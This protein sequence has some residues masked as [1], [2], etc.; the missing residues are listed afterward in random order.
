MP[1]LILWGERDAFLETAQAHESA[2]LVDDVRVPTFPAA[3][4]WVQHEAA[5][6]VNAALSAFLGARPGRRRPARQRGG[7][8]RRRGDIG[9]PRPRRR[10]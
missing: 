5:G 6:E 1:T 8:G 7:R 2:A 4:H 9:A 3:S 10:H